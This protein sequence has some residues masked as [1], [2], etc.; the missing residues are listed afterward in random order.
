MRFFP[1]NDLPKE[2]L[3]PIREAIFHALEGTRY[4]ECGWKT[5]LEIR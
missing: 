5:H 3:P 4:T 1:L 2:L